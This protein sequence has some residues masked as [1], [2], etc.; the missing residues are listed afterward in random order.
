M[1]WLIRRAWELLQDEKKFERGYLPDDPAFHHQLNA[2]YR[3]EIVWLYNECGVICLVQGNLREAVGLLRQALEFNRDVEGDTDGGPIHNHVSLNLALTQLNRGRTTAAEG[4]LLAIARSEPNNDGRV[5][6]LSILATGFLGLVAH[7]TSD[8][9]KAEKQYGEALI[10]LRDWDDKR[11]CAILLRHRADLA[12]SRGDFKAADN[13]LVEAASFASVGGHADIGHWIEVSSARNTFETAIR[14]ERAPGYG[15]GRQLASVVD[16]AQQMEIPALLCDANRLRAEILLHQGEAEMAGRLLSRN[17]AMIKRAGMDL[18]LSANLAHYANVLMLKG[19][20]EQ[21]RRLL[22]TAAAV[23]KRHR[24]R[25][26][27]QRIDR[28]R[29]KMS[30]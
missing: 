11:A 8:P 26:G 5:T 17:L 28:M 18:R 13:D 23:A 21:A 10:K 22:D 27:L 19:R 1:R 29:A 4:R 14:D 15:I 6:K 30:G 2:L 20:H 12:R 3:D 7:L 9:Q 25:L 24:N 16:Y